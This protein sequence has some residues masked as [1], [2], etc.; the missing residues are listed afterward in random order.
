MEQAVLEVGGLLQ[1][2]QDVKDA[3]ARLASHF[4]E[5]PKK[6]QLEE[7]FKLFADFFHRAEEVHK[8]RKWVIN[9][10]QKDTSRIEDFRFLQWL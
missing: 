7:C 3:A 6:F 1:G 10:K 5:D 8:V 2:V 9:N 4:C